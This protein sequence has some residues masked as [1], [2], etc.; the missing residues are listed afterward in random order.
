MLSLSVLIIMG[1]ALFIS[2]VIYLGS[3]FAVV[4]LLKKNYPDYW[5]RIGSPS[6]FD[7]NS[8]AVVFPKII[9]GRDLPADAVTRYRLHF[10][11]LRMSLLLSTMIW[12]YLMITVFLGKAPR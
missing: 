1:W 3:L 6:L 12:V 8:I 4:A 5:K 9:F 11:A 7:P 2:V 10:W